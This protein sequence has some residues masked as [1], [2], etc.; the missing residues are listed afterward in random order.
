[1]QRVPPREG[2]DNPND[3]VRSRP[4]IHKLAFCT[5]HPGSV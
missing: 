3:T 4:I 5:C 1:M 2:H